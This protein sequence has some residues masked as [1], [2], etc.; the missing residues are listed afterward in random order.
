MWMWQ[1]GTWPATLAM[2]LAESWTFQ[3]WKDSEDP[4]LL[5]CH[6][7]HNIPRIDEWHTQCTAYQ[8]KWPSDSLPVCKDLTLVR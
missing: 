3:T 6:T 8:D 2:G 5:A 7:V 4:V 1:A